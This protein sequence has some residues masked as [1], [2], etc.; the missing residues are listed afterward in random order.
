MSLGLS[1]YPISFPF[2][3]ALL[4]LGPLS[5]CFLQQVATSWTS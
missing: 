2:C 1:L 4:C 3:S 5:R